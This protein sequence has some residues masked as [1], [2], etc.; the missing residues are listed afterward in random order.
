MVFNTECIHTPSLQ[1]LTK[2]FLHSVDGWMTDWDEEDWEDDFNDIT[3]QET[4]D[5]TKQN[6]TKQN[7]TKQP[8]I[9]GGFL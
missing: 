9:I 5:E 3:T 8:G 6:E 4:G 2:G 7:K 1:D